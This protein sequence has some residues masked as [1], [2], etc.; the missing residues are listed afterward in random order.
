LDKDASASRPVQLIGHIVSHAMVSGLHHQYVRIRVFG[1]HSDNDYQ[2]I[3][4]QIYLATDTAKLMRDMGLAL[5]TNTSKT[6]VV[7]GKIFDPSKL[8]DYAKGFSI[9]R[10]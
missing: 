6:F 8:D 10:S 5:P 3:A 4:E 9:K 7:M 1:T 2:T